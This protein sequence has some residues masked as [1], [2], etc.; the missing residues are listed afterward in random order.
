MRDVAANS[1]EACARL[2][3]ALGLGGSWKCSPRSVPA[4]LELAW[5]S[6]TKRHVMPSSY[7]RFS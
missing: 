1:E 5:L 2:E 3:E 4:R 6:W 7:N